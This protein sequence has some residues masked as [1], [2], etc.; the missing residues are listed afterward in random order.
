[1]CV[2]T[3]LAT[4][5]SICV[6]IGTS[7]GA[8]GQALHVNAPATATGAD[9]P[10]VNLRVWGITSAVVGFSLNVASMVLSSVSASSEPCTESDGGK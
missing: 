7:M 6:A 8:L 2:K 10:L 1:M 3:A 5:S 9:A 4:A